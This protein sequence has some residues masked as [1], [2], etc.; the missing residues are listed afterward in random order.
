MEGPKEAQW[1]VT[2]EAQGGPSGG[3][4]EVP[5]WPPPRLTSL[6]LLILLVLLKISESS[7]NAHVILAEKSVNSVILDTLVSYMS[8]RPNSQCWRPMILPV[9]P[10]PEI[11]VPHAKLVK[12]VK[13]W[14]YS[15][16][17]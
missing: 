2:K 7:S 6:I 5:V 11:L 10:K 8:V 1:R 12:L 9:W 3:P 17:S 14:L 16:I 4:R 13:T 15:S